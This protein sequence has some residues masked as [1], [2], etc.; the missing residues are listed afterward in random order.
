M[1][2]KGSRYSKTEVIQ[3]TNAQGKSPRVLGIREIPETPSVFQHT[4]MNGE[5]LDQMAQRY[6]NDSRKYWVILDANLDVMNPFELLR[7][8]RKL[9]VP[10]NRVP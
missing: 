5:R 8:G 3:P 9:G 1:I 10:R 4:V 7:A 2:F 6:Y